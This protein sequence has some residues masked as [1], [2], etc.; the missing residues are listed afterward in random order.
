MRFFPGP[1]S[2]IRQEPP[3]LSCKLSP[4][5]LK[6]KD[7]SGKETIAD[8]KHPNLQSVCGQNHL[9]QKFAERTGCT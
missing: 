6:N 4:S 7:S 2:R 9:I 5:N 1:K 3:V 8:L